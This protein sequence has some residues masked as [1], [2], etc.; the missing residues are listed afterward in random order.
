LPNCRLAPGM[1]ETGSEVL[2]AWRHFF[3]HCICR[4]SPVYAHGETD[5]WAYFVTHSRTVWSCL[6]RSF[7]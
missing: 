6:A 1:P 3:Q 4:K 5:H 7:M 2:T